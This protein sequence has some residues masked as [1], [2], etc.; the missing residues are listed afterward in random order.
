MSWLSLSK[1]GNESWLSLCSN[2]GSVEMCLGCLYL[3]IASNS[4]SVEMWKY[5]FIVFI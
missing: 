5:V 1:C 4:E 2:S 3:C